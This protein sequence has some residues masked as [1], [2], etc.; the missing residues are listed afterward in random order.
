[1]R[2]AGWLAGV[3]LAVA[4]VAPACSSTKTATDTSCSLNSDCAAGLICALGRCRSQCESAADCPIAGSSCID[5][6]RNP[7][8]QTPA[9]KNKPCAKEADCPTPLACASDYRCRNLCLSNAECNV[10]GILGRVCARDQN[11][12]DYCADPGEASNGVIT[13]A[14]PPGAP[15]TPVAEPEGGASAIVAAL[16][17]GAIIVTN[18]GVGGGVIGAE[19]VSVSIPPGALSADIPITIQLTATPGPNGTVSQV[20]E[21]GPTGTQFAQPVTIAFSYT[22]SEL[23]GLPP[24]DFAVE[25]LPAS[26]GA[27]WSPLSQIVVDVYAHTIAGQTTHLSPYALVEQGLGAALGGDGGSAGGLDAAVSSV[28]GGSTGG[29]FPDAGTSG[30][31]SPGATQCSGNGV[32]TCAA[33]GRWGSVS[34]CASGACANG[35][36]SGSTTTGASCL[37]GG[38]GLSNCGANAESCCTSTDVP[39]GT[40]Y[41]TYTNSGDGGKGE[42]DPATVSGFR[43]DKYLVTVGRFRQ[44]VNAVLPSDGGTGWVPPA[45]SGKHTHLSSGQGLVDVGDDAG[46]AYEPGWVAADDSNLAPTA[47]NLTSGP[48][49]I[50]TWTAVPGAQDTRPID[51]A[52]WYEAYAFCIWDGGFL[53]SEAEWEYA[54]AGGNQQRQYPWGSTPPG[55]MSQYAVWNYYYP[56]PAQSIIGVGN[57]APV[58]TPT[59]GAGLWGQLDLSGSVAE[60]MLDFSSTLVD[61]C[62]DCANVTGGSVRVTRGGLF[63]GVALTAA[64]R[65]NALAPAFRTGL[66]GF[67]CARTP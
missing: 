22:D 61:P 43:L 5:D 31:C 17:Q 60:W 49:G 56:D 62:T 59:L 58:G 47:A 9:E 48:G 63:N 21:I 57:I 39:G 12:V 52:N 26:S 25:T 4:L 33:T 18:I 27:S 30:A 37:P 29:G 50:A 51:G 66:I 8:C 13:I 41:R 1:M 20:F 32:Q 19:G 11:G 16:P 34:A 10:L 2:V 53:P 36:C 46:L 42:S 6:G 23:L 28:E 44:F 67:R 54:A 64:T 14:P 15:S 3:A 24:S 65:L 7:I 38:P 40:F 55:T 35:A 45:G